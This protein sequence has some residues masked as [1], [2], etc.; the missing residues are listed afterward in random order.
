LGKVYFDGSWRYLIS[1]V[2]KQVKQAGEETAARLDDP[3]LIKIDLV[4]VE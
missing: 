3:E 4:T 2:I 1:N